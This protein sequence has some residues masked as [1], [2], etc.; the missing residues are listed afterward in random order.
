MKVVG[1]VELKPTGILMKVVGAD[2]VHIL[3]VV[4]P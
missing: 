4:P 1:D 2:L 3:D